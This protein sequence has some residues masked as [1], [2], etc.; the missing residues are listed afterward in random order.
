MHVVAA[1]AK[2]NLGLGILRRRPDGF[3][4]LRTVFQTISLADRLT[5]AYRRQGPRRVDIRCT[6][7]ELEN[8]ANLAVRAAQVMLHAGPWRAAGRLPKVYKPP[9]CAKFK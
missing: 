3:H 5:V 2:I 1:P 8:S 9:P 6:D 7:P 4:E